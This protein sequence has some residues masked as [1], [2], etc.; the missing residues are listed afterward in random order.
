V[1][2]KPVKD[3]LTFDSLIGTMAATDAHFVAETVR[4]VNA[5]LTLRN[6]CFGLHIHAYERW[7]SG[8]ARYGD[9]LV[10][11]LSDRLKARGLTN[12]GRR[13]LYDYL[14]FFRAYPDLA[15]A[16]PERAL[17]LLSSLLDP[18]SMLQ[19]SRPQPPPAATT[20]DS[21]P[22]EIVPTASAQSLLAF[23][24]E[25]LGAEIVRTAPAQSS[26]APEVLVGNLA[27]SH[28]EQ[29]LRLEDDGRRRFYEMEAVKGRWS[30]RE[31]RRQIASLLFERTGLS[32]DK[33]AL[34]R[35]VHEKAEV[36]TPGQVIRDP[37]VFE[38]FG[39]RSREVMGESALEDALIDKLQAFLLELGRGFC[40]EARQKR[41]L[42]G[43]EHFFVDLV[44][45]HRVLKCHVLVELKVDE[46]RH[47]HLGQLN[48][49][50]NYYRKHE[51]TD[52]DS[53]PIG[54]L[55]CT[56][57]NEALVEYALA[58]IDNQLFVSRYQLEL[59]TR[60]ELQ[61]VLQAGIR[62]R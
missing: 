12:V 61:K 1:V 20:Q 11:A 49:Y 8:R 5:G 28:F 47:E 29:L 7:G 56:R 45:Y 58:G 13:Q 17:V 39:L 57:K 51:R 9:R 43:G 21:D 52:G 3:A 44:F 55:L 26:L 62:E 10:A 2:S 60:E 35:T 6:W 54:L 36:L 48:T 32:T 25:S 16:V 50:V 34:L 14:H 31:L 42:I 24:S 40:F 27:Y 23:I 41:I 33:G 38:V 37:Y 30:V 46:F 18:E 4:A 53:D 15:R 59:P 22:H 19:T